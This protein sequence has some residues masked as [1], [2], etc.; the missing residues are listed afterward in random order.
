VERTQG[1]RLVSAPRRP[2][3][4]DEERGYAIGYD[5]GRFYWRF[6]GKPD[7]GAWEHPGAYGRGYRDGFAAGERAVEEAKK[8]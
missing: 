5:D 8:C 7:K 2:I 1:G 4:G 3:I 6:V